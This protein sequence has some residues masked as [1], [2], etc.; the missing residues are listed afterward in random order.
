MTGKLTNHFSID[1]P[2]VITN[3]ETYS[4]AAQVTAGDKS[5]LP[6][7]ILE[8]VCKYSAANKEVRVISNPITLC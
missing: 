5:E 1:S 4:Y 3:S 6:N 7:Q 2:L 8:I